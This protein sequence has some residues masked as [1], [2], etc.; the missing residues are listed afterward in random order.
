[1]KD[2]APALQTSM[3][4][5]TSTM[6][7]CWWTE[8]VNGDVVAATATDTNITVDGVVYQALAAFSP[9]DVETSADLS[10]DNLELEAFL[11]SPLITEADLHSGRWDYAKIKIFEVDKRNPALGR[12]RIRSGNLGHIT[13]GKAQ[14]RM[15][16]RGLTHAYGRT[17]GRLILQN[18]DVPVGSP[19]CKVDLAP[20]TVTGTVDST[21]DGRVLMIAARTEEANWFTGALFTMTSGANS[22]AG[23]AGMNLSREVKSSIPGQIELHEPFPFPIADSDA[24]STHAGCTHRPDEDCR[25]KFNNMLNNQ[26]YRDLPQFDVY[27]RATT[28]NSSSEAPVGGT[29]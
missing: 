28:S 15:E 26:G 3:A 19:R 11:R 8:L 16:L 18:C 12:H 25:D 20:F 24:Y 27:A 1:M 7:T 23:E 22:E 10:P 6:A 14:V 4:L 13:G 21:A 9:S 17:I 5:G 2:I 29:P